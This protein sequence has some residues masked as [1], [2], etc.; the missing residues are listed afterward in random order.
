MFKILALDGG[1][2]RGA[3]TAAALDELEKLSG[4][5]ATDYFDLIV[6]TSTGGILALGLGIGQ[7]PELLLD[8]YRKNG[9]RVFP[10]AKS[11]LKGLID[12]IFKPKHDPSGL[13]QCLYEVFGNKK[14]KE[15]DLPL[16]ITAFDAA[17]GHPV[18]FKTNYHQSLTGYENLLAVE[19]AMATS[20]APTFFPAAEGKNG[21]MIDGGVWANCPV[22]I[23]II[24]AL[25]L[26][27]KKIKDIRVLNIGTTTNTEFI[28]REQQEGGLF[29]WAKP[30]PAVLM[31]AARL[32]AIE[33]A[34]KLSKVFVRVDDIVDSRRFSLDDIAAVRDLEAMG[35]STMRRMSN[36]ILKQFFVRRSAWRINAE[37]TAP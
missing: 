14:F 5:K 7:P 12:W 34:K 15:I 24:E 18:I 31:H 17:C 3:Y 25:T 11:G 35:R 30:I 33:Q 29:E 6:G 22:M 26:F 32:S 9:E 37:Q 27:E 23:G 10:Q 16:A 36:N 19:A 8:L 2:I 1:G 13:N 20:A 21:I 28:T 4:K